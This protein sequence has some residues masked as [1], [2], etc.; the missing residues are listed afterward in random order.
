M[1]SVRNSTHLLLVGLLPAS[2]VVGLVEY[3]GDEQ[4]SVSLGRVAYLLA[5]AILTLA[6]Y[7]MFRPAGKVFQ[8]IESHDHDSF[9]FRFRW[10]LS[11]LLIAGPGTLAADVGRSVITIRPFN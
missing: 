5:M 7:R 6:M 2:F 3:L 10:L 1:S 4:A 11:G 9:L 8:S